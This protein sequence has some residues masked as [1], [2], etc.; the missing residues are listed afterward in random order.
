MSV[1]T[2]ADPIAFCRRLL[3][4]AMCVCL[5]LAGPA[6]GQLP[7]AG[8]GGGNEADQN[9]T[10]GDGGGTADVGDAA[11]KVTNLVDELKLEWLIEKNSTI[12]LLVVLAAA[13]G[14]LILGRLLGWILQKLGEPLK[15]RN[16]RSEA[17]WFTAAAGPLTLALLT[18]GLS[19]SIARL[20]VSETFR[21]FVGDTMTMLF[22]IAVV[23]YLYNLVEL[24]DIALRRLVGRR[25]TGLEGLLVPIIR[26]T[27]RAVLVFVAILFILDAIYQL[28]VGAWLAGLG[29]AGL[30]ISLAAQDSLK[31][32]F[33][34]VTIFL[35]RPFLK[36]SFIYYAGRYGWVEDMGFRSTRM[37]TLD[38]HLLII[39]NANIVNQDIENVGVRPYIRRVIDITITYDTPAD[40]VRRAQEIVREIFQLEGI[41]EPIHNPDNP[42]DFPPRVFFSGFN[43]ASLNILVY[44]WHRPGDWWAYLDHATRFNQQLFERYNDEG[45]DFAFPTQTLHLAGDENRPLNVGVHASPTGDP[46]TVGGNDAAKPPG[47]G[48][49]PQAEGR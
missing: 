32:V 48:K 11:D 1:M 26:K 44:Y 28:D 31:N 22:V 38:G 16:R 39:P 41:R 3:P 27:C 45:I 9:E 8:P 30:A 2:A 24:L 20:T 40:K 49:D 33:G 23:W 14:G 21:G 29:I 34:S 12:D 7:P 18:V 10:K 17:L 25:K 15:R 46:I 35:D 19:V 6:A 4:L 13:I 42:D 37:R 43:S 47:G 36:D 5:L